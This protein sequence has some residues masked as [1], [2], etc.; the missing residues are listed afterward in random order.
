MFYDPPSVGPDA[1]LD[2]QLN[3]GGEAEQLVMSFP[4]VVDD[5]PACVLDDSGASH[6]LA[7]VAKQGL[8]GHAAS[9]VVSAA[10][11]KSVPVKSYVQTRVR[12]QALSEVIKLYVVDMPAPNLH[13][14]LGQCWLKAVLC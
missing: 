12:C 13:V 11:Q 5:C 14:V 1:S 4:G 7:V 2:L 8:R 9:G 3:A 10:G 6:N